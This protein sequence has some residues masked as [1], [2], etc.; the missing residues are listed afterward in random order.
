[1]TVYRRL[2]DVEVFHEKES[3]RKHLHADH[4]TSLQ[5]YYSRCILNPSCKAGNI[6]D[7]R[8]KCCNK[9][10]KEVHKQ[11]PLSPK[12]KRKRKVRSYANMADLSDKEENS[13]RT[14][15]RLKKNREEEKIKIKIEKEYLSEDKM[16][17]QTK[18]SESQERATSEVH[19]DDKC[20]K[21]E[22]EEKE[23]GEIHVK[24]E[25][26]EE[27]EVAGGGSSIAVSIK[28]RQI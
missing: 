10:Q 16:H 21:Q 5:Q 17:P 28:E 13:S 3:I 26:K 8:G 19:R 11:Q 6:S 24:K 12:K 1:M 20:I 27:N 14:K 7:I 2:C 15:K 9:P 4:Q 18:V 23:K 25:I 22:S